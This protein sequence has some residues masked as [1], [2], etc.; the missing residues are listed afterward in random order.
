MLPAR[1]CGTQ[2]FTPKLQGLG[3]IPKQASSIWSERLFQFLMP[4]KPD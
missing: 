4:H 2:R 3:D 1:A